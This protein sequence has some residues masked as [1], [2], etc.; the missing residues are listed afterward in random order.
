MNAYDSVEDQRLV[1]LSDGFLAWLNGWER[2]IVALPLSKSEKN[3]YLLSYQT[4]EGLK[5]TTKSFMALTTEILSEPGE[6][7][8]LIPQKLN[9]DKLE[10][11]FAKLR[12]G[13][14]DSDNPTVNEVRHR[15]MAFIV[16]GRSVM[17]PRQANVVVDEDEEVGTYMPRRKRFRK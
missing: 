8:Y 10:V 1:W 14:G 13:C 9:Q 11:F 12:R 7:L 17:A 5:I 2:E 6:D 15:I 4:S 3:R 16:A